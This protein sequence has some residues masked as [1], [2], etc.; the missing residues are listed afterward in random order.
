MRPTIITQ[1]NP[2]IGTLK[3]R[4]A[5]LHQFSTYFCLT[6]STRVAN[7]YGKGDYF[8]QLIQCRKQKSPTLVGDG[9]IH[10]FSLNEGILM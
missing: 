2:I 8:S 9:F 1:S 10:A 3:A 6:R 4:V 5:A 7:E